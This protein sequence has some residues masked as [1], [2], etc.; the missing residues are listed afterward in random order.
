MQITVSAANHPTPLRAESPYAANDGSSASDRGPTQVTGADDRAP[1]S[2]VAIDDPRLRVGGTEVVRVPSISDL[3]TPYAA[4]PTRG[5]QS[6]NAHRP[7]AKPQEI[8]AVAGDTLSHLAAKYLGANTKANRDAIVKANASL[9]SDPNKIIVGHTYVMPAPPAATASVPGAAPTAAA[10]PTPAPAA[11]STT[12]YW[13][14]VQP[15]DSLIRIATD[16]LGDPK[17]FHAIIELNKEL[18]NG[19]DAIT[20]N[21]KLRLPSKPI[22]SARS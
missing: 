22:A 14:T 4:D 11:E 17:A 9:A 19:G 12:A 1:A 6:A 18:L 7:T 3:E 13:Y 5:A 2:P 16:Q 20:P 10:P 15:G 8:Q 21:M